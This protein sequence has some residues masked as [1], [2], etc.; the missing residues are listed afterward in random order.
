MSS[1]ELQRANVSIINAALNQVSLFF[2]KSVDQQVN[3]FNQ[4]NV[5]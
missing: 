3:I 1:F 5:F 2:S 4:T